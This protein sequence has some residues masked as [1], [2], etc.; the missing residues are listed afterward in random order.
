MNPSVIHVTRRASRATLFLL[1]AAALLLP[2]AGTRAET[3]YD[4]TMGLRLNDDAR[5][6]VNLT[7]EYF[8]PPQAVATT[9]IR[10]T[11]RPGDDFPAILL[12]ARASKRSPEAILDLRLGGMSWGDI[13]VRLDLRPDFLFV[14]LD[15]DPGPPYGKAW[16]HYKQHPGKGKGKAQGKGGF[17]ISDRDFIELTKLQVTAGY[18]KVSPYTVIAERQKGI[19]IERYAAEEHRKA[20][21]PKGGKPAGKHAPKGSSHGNGHGGSQGKP[22]DKPNHP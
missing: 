9:V 8:G 21:P 12:L 18:F 5:L 11:R 2:A 19:S 4:V 15:R 1:I 10:R 7:N 14:G 13:M 6:F 16:G 20:H 22:D 3:F 17:V